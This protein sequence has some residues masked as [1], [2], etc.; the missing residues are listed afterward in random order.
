MRSLTVGIDGYRPETRDEVDS[1]LREVVPGDE[2]ALV[3]IA[4]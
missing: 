4:H 1:T 2:M 3:E